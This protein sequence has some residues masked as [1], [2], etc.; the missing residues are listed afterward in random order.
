[1]NLITRASDTD[2]DTDSDPDPELASL[3]TF[4]DDLYLEDCRRDL[5]AIEGIP[6][7]PSSFSRP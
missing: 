2:T 7:G 1:M 4:S 5:P 3:D 6:E